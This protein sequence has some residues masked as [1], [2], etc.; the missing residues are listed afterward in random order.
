MR[1]T[2][3]TLLA[4]LDDTLEPAEARQIGK[5]L[6]DSPAAQ[7]IVERLKQVTRRRR[8]TAPPI[9]GAE[10]ALDAN[11]VAEYLDNE[12]DANSVT[13]FE[14]SCLN[15]DLLLAEV[16]AAHQILTLVLGEPALVPPTARLRM[17]RLVKGPESLP[18]RKPTFHVLGQ[19]VFAHD[20]A[21][22]DDNDDTLLL[23]FSSS[24]SGGARRWLVPLAAICLLVGAGLALW[25]SL[26]PESTGLVKRVPPSEIRNEIQADPGKTAVIEANSANKGTEPVIVEQPAKPAEPPAN[27]ANKVEPNPPTPA[28][29][30]P[31][32]PKLPNTE[33]R[34]LGRAVLLKSAPS[35]LLERQ[36]DKPPFRRVPAESRISSMDY[37]V[38]LPGCK[39]E[40]RLDSGMAIQLWGNLPE[41]SRIP[42]LES[43]VVLHACS[44]QIDAEF[45]LDH[46]RVVLVNRKSVGP[47]Q[48]RVRFR[49]EAWDITLVEPGTE[50]GV[51]LFGSCEPYTREAGG[52]ES[53]QDLIVMTLAGEASLKIGYEQ[54]LLPQAHLFAWDNIAG[55]SRIARALPKLPDWYTGKGA[56]VPGA[57]NFGPALEELSK[58]ASVKTIDVAL[59]E[60]MHDGDAVSRVLAIRCLAAL[61]DMAAL[62]DALADDKRPDMREAAVESLKHLLGFG[63]RNDN[64]LLRQARL[65]NYSEGQMLTILQLL[66]GFTPQDWANPATRG[67]TADFLMHERTAIRQLAHSILIAQVPEGK[68]IAYDAGA[69]P[70]KRERGADEWRMLVLR[71]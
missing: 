31:G 43:A 71:R 52:G 12:L 3:R 46:G 38:S 33:R 13:E 41:S 69:E 30:R 25:I 15:S 61:G 32:I 53:P 50:V 40:L 20:L 37:L 7:E 70:R 42:V 24:G 63:T 57:R 10:P 29:S 26:W 27:V 51:E 49:E 66:H 58:R 22:A 54:Y 1:L 18:N 16:A 23:G 47:V 39:T 11:T 59:A 65:K 36:A 14:E 9:A 60:T 55:P 44:G 34:E 17:Y 5:K 8:L 45:T 56:A 67:L 19:G 4:Y 68:S 21:Q 2:L 64:D 35:I 6:A 48:V 62:L 28:T